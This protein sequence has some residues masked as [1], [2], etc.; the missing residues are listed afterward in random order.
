M[1]RERFIN[2]VRRKRERITFQRMSAGRDA[3]NEPTNEWLDLFSTR[4]AKLSAPGSEKY[5]SAQNAA[6]APTIF[7][8]RDEA[9]TRGL[10]PSDRLMHGNLAYN[11]VSLE[12]PQSG[13]DIRIAAVADLKG[14]GL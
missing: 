13:S 12:Q 7:E 5:A 4:A 8:V 1:A 2:R 10:L 11:I 3:M 14:A 6:S 9:R